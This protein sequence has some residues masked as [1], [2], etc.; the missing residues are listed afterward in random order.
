MK[1]K[2]NKSIKKFIKVKQI[3]IREMKIKYNRKKK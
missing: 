1:S 2:K 3:A